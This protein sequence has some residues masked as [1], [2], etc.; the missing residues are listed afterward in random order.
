[1]V[2]YDQ[3]SQNHS[4]T[5]VIASQINSNQEITS[6]DTTFST[7]ESMDRVDSYA[8]DEHREVLVENV[9]PLV[10]S[11]HLM[12]MH[13]FDGIRKPNLKCLMQISAEPAIPTNITETLAN[14]LWR[15]A[16]E[17]E[18][19]ALERKFTWI[20]V[21]RNVT[22]NLLSCKWVYKQ[23]MDEAGN[24]ICHKARLVGIGSN[25]RNGIDFTE[26]FTL[27]V[28]EATIRIILSIAVTRNWKLRQLDVSN[29]F[30]HGVLEDEVYMHQPPGYKNSRHQDYVYKLQKSIYGLR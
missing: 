18:M 2:N 12:V 8:I 1:M 3:G 26:T 15:Q 7:H 4:M 11:A 28:K 22:K 25:Q 20:L 27:V 21:P 5:P 16:M 10:A 17:D 19:E 14:P 30:L 9:E 29:A 24:V 23:K 13:A 6:E